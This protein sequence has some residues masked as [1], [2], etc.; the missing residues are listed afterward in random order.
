MER[1]VILL[2]DAATRRP[3]GTL[4]VDYEWKIDPQ[5]WL[6]EGGY[7]LVVQG[8]EMEINGY[9]HEI[10]IDLEYQE[11]DA[12]KDVW[13]MLV[14]TLTASSCTEICEKINNL[15]GKITSLNPDIKKPK[16]SFG[17]S[18][19]TKLPQFLIITNAYKLRYSENFRKIIA[20]HKCS[21]IANVPYTS[22]VGIPDLPSLVPL[23]LTLD[24][25]EQN[26]LIP[27]SHKPKKYTRNE[28]VLL[29]MGISPQNYS[30]DNYLE[31]RSRFVGV[32]AVEISKIRASLL[33]VNSGNIVKTLG[34]DDRLVLTFVLKR[35]L[36]LF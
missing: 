3:N 23:Y 6:K 22:T 5:I 1:Q 4:F 2:S 21:L 19:V 29:V 24:I 13:H 28:G 35:R 36:E 25:L 20:L 17:E 10:E 15:F 8:L 12:D 34:R 14:R 32:K 31:S 7:G 26:C 33:Y 9:Q 30:L 27:I 11:E 16:F 18:T